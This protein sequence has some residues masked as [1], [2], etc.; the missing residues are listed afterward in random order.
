MFLEGFP[1]TPSLT[2]ERQRMSL[3]RQALADPSCEETEVGTST[4]VP[5]TAEQTQVVSG[6]AKQTASLVRQLFERGWFDF[7]GREMMAGRNPGKKDW[8]RIF[9]DRLIKGGVTRAD[10]TLAYQQELSLTQGSARVRT[11]KAIAAFLAGGLIVERS[12]Y[13]QLTKNQVR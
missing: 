12:G 1:E 11:C 2:R 8:Q 3:V 4:R 10:L 5:L 7:A 13:L 6:L 9:C